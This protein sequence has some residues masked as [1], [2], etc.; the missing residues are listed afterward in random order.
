MWNAVGIVEDRVQTEGQKA[1]E[2]TMIEEEKSRSD[3][4]IS[5]SIESP[6][7]PFELEPPI[8]SD[9]DAEVTDSRVQ[10]QLFG[11]DDVRRRC[12]SR[13]SG[14]LAHLKVI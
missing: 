1:P 3:A 9:I 14:D 11:D 10:K 2:A 6:E 5:S 8:I 4:N 13:S 12:V 7:Q